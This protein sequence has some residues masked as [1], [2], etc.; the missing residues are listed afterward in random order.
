MFCNPPIGLLHFSA[1]ISTRQKPS[2]TKTAGRLRI[3]DDWKAISIIALTVLLDIP[4]LW[5]FA[6]VGMEKGVT[7]VIP[8]PVG[9]PA[10]F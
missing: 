3:G 9:L 6:A 7:C 8:H 2:K 5:S 4:L 1:M 10:I